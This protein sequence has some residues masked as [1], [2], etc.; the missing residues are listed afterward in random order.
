VVIP[1]G[2]EPV[3]KEMQL[4]RYRPDDYLFGRKLLT[5]SAM[6]V[7]PNHI[8]TRHK[9]YTCRLGMDPEKGLYSWKHSGVVAAY[10]ATGKD[11]YSLMRQLRHRDLNTTMIYL[12][13]MG[14]VQN[15]V[16][17]NAL[18]A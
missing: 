14:L 8:S 18:V 4:H 16:F 3:L 10:R 2:L 11:V 1:V 13:S 6:Y 7:N 15:D 9:K 12:N 17:R 5:S